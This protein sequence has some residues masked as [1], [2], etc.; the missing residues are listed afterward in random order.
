MTNPST[1]RWWVLLMVVFLA[2]LLVLV[3][4]VSK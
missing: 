3:I 4:S 2:G 1:S